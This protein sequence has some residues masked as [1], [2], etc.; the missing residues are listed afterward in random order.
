MLQNK[1]KN[2]SIDYTYAR[3]ARRITVTHGYSA[4]AFTGN[5]II[6]RASQLL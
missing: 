4:M 6:V 2:V 1:I 5:D 3:A